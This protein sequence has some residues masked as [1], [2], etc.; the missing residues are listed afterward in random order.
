MQRTFIRKTLSVLLSILMVLSVFGGLAITA[1]AMEIFFTVATEEGTN[2]LEVEPTDSVDAVKAKIQDKTGVA[3]QNQLLTFNGKVLEDNRF[4]SDYNIQRESTLVLSVLTEWTTADA[5]PTAA[6]YYKLTTDVTLGGTWN[7]PQGVTEL[8]LNGYG[9]K[10]TSG[11]HVI[12][13]DGAGSHLILND[14]AP[15]KLHYFDKDENGKAVN[16]NDDSGALT[17]TGGYIAGGTG[18]GID[19]VYWNVGGAVCLWYN[20]TFTMNGGSLI[21]NSAADGAAVLIHDGSLFTLN[22]G[23]LCYNQGG[24]AVTIRT[25]ST[26]GEPGT[27]GKFVMNGGEISDNAAS[28]VDNGYCYGVDYG[29]LHGGAIKNNTGHGVSVRNL[30]IDGDIEISGNGSYGVNFDTY[31]NLSGSP[32]IKDNETD[33]Q[34]R[35][36]IVPS[37]KT[38]TIAGELTPQVPIGVTTA[39]PTEGNPVTFTSGWATNMEG[40]NPA[41]CFYSDAGYPMSA[42]PGA[43]LTTVY[44][45]YDV[46]FSAG[47]GDGSMATVHVTPKYQL[48]ANPFTPPE[49]QLFND[50][51]LDTDGN[52]YKTGKYAILTGDSVFTAQ[53]VDAALAY[54]AP[55]GAE[56]E[57]AEIAKVLPGT[58]ITLPANPFTAP[59]GQLFNGWSDG[60]DVYQP[61]DSYTLDA[62]TT[63]E[64]QWIDG[65]TVTFDTAGGSEI[66]SLLLYPEES[67]ANRGSLATA[68]DGFVFRGWI[69]DGSYAAWY[70]LAA[71]VTKD[72]VLTAVW[73][74]GVNVE[75]SFESTNSRTPPEGW[76][77]PQNNM[78]WRF[79]ASLPSYYVNDERIKLSPHGGNKAAY[80]A[81]GRDDPVYLTMPAQDLTGQSAATLSFWYVNTPDLMEGTTVPKRLEVYYRIGTEGEWTLL[82]QTKADEIMTDWTYAAVPIPAALFTQDVYFGFLDQA[83]DENNDSMMSR[84]YV[85]LDDVTLSAGGHNVTYTAE[86]DTLTATCS[87]DPC[88][89]EDGKLALTINA[90]EHA[91]YGDGKSAEATLAG[92]DKFNLLLDLAIDGAVTYTKDGEPLAAAPTDA[93]EYTVSLTAAI[94][95]EDYTISTSYIV[96]KADPDYTVPTGLTATYGDTLGSV[97]LPEGWAW[98]AAYDAATLVG[99]VGDNTFDAVYTPADAANYNNAAASVTVTVAPKA[100]TVTADAKT[101]ARG[102]ADPALTYT[103]DGLIDGDAITVTLSRAAGDAIG[104]YAITAEI[105]AGGNYEVAFEGATFTITANEDDLAADAVE[106]LIDAIGEV[107]YT[108]ECKAKIDAARAAY[109]ALTG[110]QKALVGNYP[111]LT[112][113]EARYAALKAAAEAPEDPTEPTNPET[114]AEEGGCPVCG[115]S[116]NGSIFDRLIGFI[117]SLIAIFRNLFSGRSFNC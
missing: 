114:P 19:G 14:S 55:N 48:P 81:P 93:G 13:L 115:K 36:V 17:F 47:E 51:L 64:A 21:G 87:N 49:G 58:A 35:N 111:T 43:E 106:S 33:G 37:G 117:H 54:L 103:V 27:P 26:W 98:A 112:A 29:E 23:R 73:T 92:L 76:T 50:W 82:Y 96:D 74:E 56:G 110:A 63:F 97:E 15:D 16:I 20:G 88:A 11:G 4:L 22:G 69:A 94:D 61:G 105:D 80:A 104:E 70:D 60:T 109:N 30:T 68:R 44:V 28:A 46:S 8:D 24:S 41:D 113:A 108:D 102:E 42:V 90:P 84:S 100:L 45:A 116:H 57:T 40:M 72:T 12:K 91:V 101:K 5:M 85:F 10:L 1:N 95:G 32:L 3:P 59:E 25:G 52:H 107:A 38:V 6:G 31:L 83:V 89:F 66:A 67:V 53:F 75:E 99:N 7:L 71:P 2:V 9:V 62:T 78:T 39:D 18:A 65:F 34:K 86:G 79:S 77:L